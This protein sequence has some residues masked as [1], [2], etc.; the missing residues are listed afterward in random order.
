M[1]RVSMLAGVC[2]LLAFGS[3]TARAQAPSASSL[4]PPRP[5]LAGAVATLPENGFSARTASAPLRLDQSLVGSA[6]LGISP[7]P[8]SDAVPARYPFATVA[9][10]GIRHR[11]PGV[12][13]MVVGA[14]G[15]I[16]GLLIRESVVTVVS[17]G[18]GLV[19]LYIYVR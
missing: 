10:S 8:V 2:A 5:A 15:I 18:V 1:S 12:A 14:A 9:S 6:R 11:G 7:A 4:Q 13:L 16:T 19:G 3:G 17:A